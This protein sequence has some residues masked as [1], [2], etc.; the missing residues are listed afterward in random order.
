MELSDGLY[1]LAGSTWKIALRRLFELVYEVM[2][3]Q[4]EY[5]QEAL[6][7]ALIH[8]YELS[9]QSGLPSFM[10]KGGRTSQKT[11]KKGRA[12]KRQQQHQ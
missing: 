10:Q 11:P 8:D 12:N 9:G 1:Q 4:I 6:K 2:K 3:V 7:L 5:S